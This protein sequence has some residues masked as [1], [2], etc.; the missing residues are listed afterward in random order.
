MTVRRLCEIRCS[1]FLKH[2]SK[3]PLTPPT[4]IKLNCYC[5]KQCHIVNKHTTNS[6]SLVHNVATLTLRSR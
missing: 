2:L 6:F 4:T 5:L 1:S 3:H